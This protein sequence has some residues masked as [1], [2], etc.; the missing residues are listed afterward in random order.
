MGDALL[1]AEELLE[2]LPAAVVRREL[3]DRLGK[4]LNDLSTSDRQVRRI[5]DA[6]KITKLI[7]FGSINHQR[8]ALTTMVDW[9]LTVGED[10]E[11]AQDAEALR[12][13]V[14]DYTKDLNKSIA[15]L[16]RLI[17]QHWQSVVTERFQ[18]LRGLGELL[19]LMNVSNDLGQRLKRCGEM[20]QASTS[21]VSNTELLSTI[22]NLLAQYEDLQE[23][24]R[25]EI[26][27]DEVGD[28]I[29]ALAEK[30]ATLVMV[31]LKVREWLADHNALDRLGLTTRQL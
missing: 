13:A 9:A 4:A 27:E 21:V 31:T 5:K 2:Q 29:N 24:R 3:G 26:S 11:K 10:L 8:E 12:K 1:E 22:E 16:E 19:A 20:G 28:F 23:E 6:L 18:P 7:Q 30:R 14:Y 25:R 15:D 17:R